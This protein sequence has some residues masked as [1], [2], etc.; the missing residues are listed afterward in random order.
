VASWASPPFVQSEPSGHEGRPSVLGGRSRE[1]L[2]APRLFPNPSLLAIVAAETERR[3][4]RALRAWVNCPCLETRRAFL[5]AISAVDVAR[6]ALH[7]KGGTMPTETLTL[8]ESR[9]LGEG[10]DSLQKGVE[11]ML[12]TIRGMIE[13]LGDEDE[14]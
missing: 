8:E 12:V 13:D 3:A 5:H 11:G 4:S 10:L 7:K 1:P 2:R 9:R 14:D 6:R